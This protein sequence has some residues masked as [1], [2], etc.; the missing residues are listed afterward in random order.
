MGK[1]GELL[2]RIPPAKRGWVRTMAKVG[3]GI[4][5][6]TGTLAIG[7][8]PWIFCFW[9]LSERNE[10]LRLFLVGSV[11]LAISCIAGGEWLKAKGGGT[12]NF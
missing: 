1:V 3:Y 10:T 8:I 4:C 11:V 2:E 7:C 6:V 5:V 12:V 9:V